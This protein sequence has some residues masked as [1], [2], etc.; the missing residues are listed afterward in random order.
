MGK[1]N[2]KISINNNNNNDNAIIITIIKNDENWTKMS[3][4]GGQ[5]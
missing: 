4:V 1:F 5:P 3:S 2:H